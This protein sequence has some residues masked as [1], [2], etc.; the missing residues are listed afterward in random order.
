MNEGMLESVKKVN[1]GD[2]SYYKLKIDEQIYSLWSSLPETIKKGSEVQFDYQ[3]R[4]KDGKE[5]KNIT[6]ITPVGG[7]GPDDTDSRLAALSVGRWLADKNN[8][9]VELNELLEKAD[10]IH[11]WLLGDTN[12]TE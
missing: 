5:F 7:N 12:E 2:N 10:K 4:E 1:S 8:D 6:D 3:T 11:S 9:E